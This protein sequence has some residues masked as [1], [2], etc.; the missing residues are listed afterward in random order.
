MKV[1]KK[2]NKSLKF[3]AVFASLCLLAY[4]LGLLFM[5]VRIKNIEE[6]YRNVETDLSKEQKALSIR[7]S[8]EKSSESIDK[9]RGFFVSKN[10]NLKF[11]E[12]IEKVA[13][14]S[15]IEFEIVSIDP[16]PNQEGSFKE[17]L[18]VKMKATGSWGNL[19]ALLAKIEKMPFLVLVTKSDF[20]LD[21]PGIWTA[22]L[23]F[24]IY[25]EK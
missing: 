11:I 13:R 24:E 17:D 25:K 6:S 14:N 18:E 16:K 20:I 7:S 21:E 2:Q 23:H 9:I 19:G 12:E 15:G 8:V 3:S 22:N 4:I 10:D 1:E 5:W